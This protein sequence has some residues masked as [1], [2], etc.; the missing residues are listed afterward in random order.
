MQN[1]SVRHDWSLAEIR[2]LFLLPFIKLIYYALESHQRY[3][4]KNLMQIS[5]LIS[6]KTGSCPEDCAYCAQSSHHKT[7]IKSHDLLSLNEVVAKAKDIKDIGGTR[8]C[9]GA[10]WSFPTK[11]Q[12]EQIL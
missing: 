8:C 10:A 6:I 7:D 3:F 1:S 2:G 5:S 12:F 4:S 9:M 11:K